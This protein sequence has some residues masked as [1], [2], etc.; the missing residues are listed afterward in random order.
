MDEIATSHRTLLAIRLCHNYQF[1]CTKIITKKSIR[2]LI[3]QGFSPF[4]WYNSEVR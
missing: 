4:L 1:F 3:L 2:T